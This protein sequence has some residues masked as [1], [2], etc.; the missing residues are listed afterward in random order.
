M[1][2]RDSTKHALRRAEECAHIA[3]SE[4]II[5]EFSI[6]DETGTPL[7]IQPLKPSDEEIAARTL[8]Q[9]RAE[10]V[11]AELLVGDDADPPVP[12]R[13]RVQRV[14]GVLDRDARRSVNNGAA[15]RA[16]RRVGKMSRAGRN[17]DVIARITTQY[18]N[19]K[20]EPLTTP[21]LGGMFRWLKAYGLHLPSQEALRKILER[22]RRE[23]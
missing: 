7:P 21:F 6:L 20:H 15:R 9:F 5:H 2:K 3:L 4:Q 16:G 1:A 14:L 22:A 23:S 12:A 13:D 19:W 11:P 8:D 18:P 10:G 17:A